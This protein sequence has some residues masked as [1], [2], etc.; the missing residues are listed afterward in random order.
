M[1]NVRP[2]RGIGVLVGTDSRDFGGSSLQAEG[3]LVGDVG[4]VEVEAGLLYGAVVVGLQVLRMAAEE[5]RIPEDYEG[6][7]AGSAHSTEALAHLFSCW[8]QA[9]VEVGH[10]YTDLEGRGGDHSAQVP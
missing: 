9:E 6:R 3:V 8:R 1:K 7:G 4:V 10:V 5:V 2:F